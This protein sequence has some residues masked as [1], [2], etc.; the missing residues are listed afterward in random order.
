MDKNCSLKSNSIAG[1]ERL[2]PIVPP[3]IQLQEI[4]IEMWGSELY[5][6]F[7]E[8]NIDLFEYE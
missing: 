4:W 6:D 7:Q 8:D 5:D 1:F 2:R 3:E